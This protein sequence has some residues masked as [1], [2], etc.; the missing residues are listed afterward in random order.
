MLEREA[1]VLEL[2]IKDGYFEK[3][4]C[5]GKAEAAPENRGIELKAPDKK[6][7]FDEAAGKTNGSA[8]QN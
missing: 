2:L 4:R 5:P 1:A 8:G 7:S 6:C 3:K